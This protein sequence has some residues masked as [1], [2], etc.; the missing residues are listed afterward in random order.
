[1]PFGQVRTSA[2]PI[3]Q[4]DFAYTGQRNNSYINLMDYNSRWY[5]DYLNRWSQPDSIIP[6]D[7]SQSLNRLSYVENNPINFN[8]PSGHCVGEDGTQ[9]S[10]AN[11]ECMVSNGTSSNSTTTS[12]TTTVNDLK[13]KSQ[14][15]MMFTIYVMRASD[16]DAMD[17]ETQAEEGYGYGEPEGKEPWVN[18]LSDILGT[19]E[20]FIPGQN[21][22]F[23]IDISLGWQ[24]DNLGLLLGS[25][26]VRNGSP[27]IVGVG[28][29]I[30]NNP[31]TTFL[32]G[33]Q[34]FAYQGETITM[35]VNRYTNKWSDVSVEIDIASG[36]GFPDYPK[37]VIEI[38]VG[39]M[40]FPGCSV[41][42][43]YP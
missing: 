7:N 17:L 32:Q 12:T 31:N 20:N 43:V 24:N 3:T 10:D 27:T 28:G 33:P 14:G 25:L 36:G 41:L 40:P 13:I 18:L 16:L 6:D 19:V 15:E 21:K 37:P 26:T 38:P 22:V 34:Q 8:D 30:I 5:D 42:N 9:L 11:P 29:V 39:S 23:P 1:M 35:G 4:T 2:S